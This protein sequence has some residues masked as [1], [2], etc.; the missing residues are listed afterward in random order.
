MHVYSKSLSENDKSNLILTMK[1]MSGEEGTL[2][3]NFKNLCDLGE[4]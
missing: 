2:C 1:W 3:M 4:L